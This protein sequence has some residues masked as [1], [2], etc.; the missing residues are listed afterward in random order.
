MPPCTQ[1]N[2][3]SMR[4]VIGNDSNDLTHASYTSAEY[5]CMPRAHRVDETVVPITTLVRSQEKQRSIL[6][7]ILVEK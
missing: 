2:L 4:A 5:L 3:P 7:H 1:K 6:T